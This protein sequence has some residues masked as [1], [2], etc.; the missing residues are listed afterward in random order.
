MS[1]KKI[2]YLSEDPTISY[3]RYCL[4]SFLE[5]TSEVEIDNKEYDLS[6]VDTI[7]E[8]LK[9]AKME[10]IEVKNNVPNVE[11]LNKALVELVVS[12]REKYITGVKIRGSYEKIEAAKEKA[13]E[14]QDIDNSVG[15]FVGEVGKW[16]PFNP[17]ADSI[18]EQEYSNEKLNG[19]MKGYRENQAKAKYLFEK[20]KQ[21]L[22]QK[23]IEEN[24]IIKLQN[25]I[26]DKELEGEKDDFETTIENNL[27]VDSKKETA[28]EV[29][30]TDTDN[31]A[32]DNLKNE[33]IT[34][35][36]ITNIFSDNVPI[37]K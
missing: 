5:R 23:N 18:Q 21:D 3:Q 30:E 7:N 17:N 25:K 19:L 15:I 35:E 1:E 14:L 8:I 4:V 26:K 36:L 34:K 24:E 31:S 6:S 12:M 13:Q 28:P 27:S 11:Q 16:L 9:D 33:K 22:I 20:R 29:I 2:D 10:P 37:N 32:L